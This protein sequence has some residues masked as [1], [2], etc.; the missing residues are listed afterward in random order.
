MAQRGGLRAWTRGGCCGCAGY[1]RRCIR[2]A[3]PAPVNKAD[4]LFDGAQLHVPLPQPSRAGEASSS[5]TGD[6]S[7]GHWFQDTRD[8]CAA[9]ESWGLA[10]PRPN[11]GGLERG[12]SQHQRSGDRPAQRTQSDQAPSLNALVALGLTVPIRSYLLTRLHPREMV[13]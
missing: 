7:V 10:R 3:H 4:L 6:F 13:K 5:E 9:C 12:V 2:E 1:W 11:M 8:D